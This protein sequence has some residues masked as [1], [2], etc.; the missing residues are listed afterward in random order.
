MLKTAHLLRS[1]PIFPIAG[2]LIS[3]FGFVGGRPIAQ[4]PPWYTASFA[5]VKV[6]SSNAKGPE[7]LAPGPA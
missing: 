2:T 4:E 7:K 5:N 3:R 6:R 1:P